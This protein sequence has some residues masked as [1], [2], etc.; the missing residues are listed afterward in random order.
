MNPLDKHKHKCYESMKGELLKTL[1]LD[2]RIDKIPNTNAAPAV[3]QC[4]LLP[5]RLRTSLAE[6]VPALIRA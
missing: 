3:T 1:V 6:I 2:Q 4:R 5:A